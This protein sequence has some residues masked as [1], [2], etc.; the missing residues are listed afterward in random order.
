MQVVQR[1]CSAAFTRRISAVTIAIATVISLI[2]IARPA[3]AQSLLDRP[4]NISTDWVG[5]T[6]ILY[7]NFVHR[8]TTSPAPEKKVSN[9]PTFLIATGISSKALIGVNYATNSPLTARYP[10]EWEF[11]GRYAPLQQ[12]DGAP[13]DL[14]AQA[15]YNL[16]VEGM[17]GEISIA[18]RD[19][20]VRLVAVARTIADTLHGDKRRYSFGGGGTLRFGRFVA[21]AGD[22]ATLTSRASGEKVAWSAGVHLAL[23]NTPHTLSIHVSNASTSTLQG[24]A[25]GGDRKRYGF[26]FTIPIHASRFF[27]NPE[28]VSAAG[29]EQPAGAATP[30]MPVTADS[31]GAAKQVPT[32]GVT[33]TPAPT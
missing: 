20:P 17:D 26:E 25:R 27:S 14:G 15:D 29:A 13:F 4:D 33:P 28:P 30:S 7:F 24:F 19:G 2:V 8:F 9:F 23:P 31:A 18:R 12:D 32:P 21:L 11:F 16:A 5:G 10:N 1:F 6:G 22:A 3:S